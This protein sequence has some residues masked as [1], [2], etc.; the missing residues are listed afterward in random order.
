MMFPSAL[1][2]KSSSGITTAPA[3]SS[4]FTTTGGV[5]LDPGFPPP[6]GGVVEVSFSRI[7][8]IV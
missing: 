3:G 8:A 1:F 2:V 5:T 7:T 6:V 4:G